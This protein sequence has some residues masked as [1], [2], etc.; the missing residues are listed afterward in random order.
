MFC[1]WVWEMTISKVKSFTCAR[2]SSCQ[3]N[4]LLHLPEPLNLT[5]AYICLHDLFSFV[6]SEAGYLGI[7]AV[8]PVLKEIADSFV[9]DDEN[10]NKK[11]YLEEP[12]DETTI[13][14]GVVVNIFH[15]VIEI[16]ARRIKKEPELGKQ[17]SW[18]AVKN[19]SGS[20]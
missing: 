5:C 16:L 10:R 6:F 18:L 3:V 9:P 8:L 2:S 15:K 17:V 13:I 7:P 11:K 14:L 20:T 12:E 1:L 4:I 19:F